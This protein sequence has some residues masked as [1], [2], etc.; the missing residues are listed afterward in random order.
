MTTQ[1]QRM[2]IQ[3]DKQDSQIEDLFKSVREIKNMNLKVISGFKGLLI[4]FALMVG[5]D[6]GI[7]DLLMKLL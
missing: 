2:Q 1:Q 4:G 3:L 6:F 7:G 5:V